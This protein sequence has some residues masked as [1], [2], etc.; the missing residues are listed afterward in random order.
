VTVALV[1]GD[2][3]GQRSTVTVD[4]QPWR[5]AMLDGDGRR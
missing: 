4:G 3:D 5:S 2:G 1:D